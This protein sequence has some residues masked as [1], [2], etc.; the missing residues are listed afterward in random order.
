MKTAIVLCVLGLGLVGASLVEGTVVLDEGEAASVTGGVCLSFE[1]YTCVEGPGDCN[2]FNGYYF[3]CP[4]TGQCVECDL[5]NL[6]AACN[7][8]ASED[9]YIEDTLNCGNKR[10]GLCEPEGECT[11]MFP[12]QDPCD[13]A[14]ACTD[15][16]P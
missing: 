5:N 3:P 14:M 4:G 2:D 1:G 15:P 8:N 11:D 6:S 16:C 9:C 12:S 13:E 7:V 10:G